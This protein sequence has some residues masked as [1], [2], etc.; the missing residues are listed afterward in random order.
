ML[1]Q[2]SHKNYFC[3]LSAFF[4]V[5]ETRVLVCHDVLHFSQKQNL[6][7]PIL[8]KNKNEIQCLAKKNVV[9]NCH[10]HLINLFEGG[11]SVGAVKRNYCE[12]SDSHV[13]IETF[14]S[15]NIFA[16]TYSVFFHPLKCL[17]SWF[18]LKIESEDFFSC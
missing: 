18:F 5:V 4:L 15:I 12:A 11:P 2:F 7:M 3:S 17:V 8:E 6:N 1:P 10:L 16:Y 13:V 9:K 14:I